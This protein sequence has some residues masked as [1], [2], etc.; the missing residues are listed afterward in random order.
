MLLSRQGERVKRC[1]SVS[2]E[3]SVLYCTDHF[4]SLK[5]ISPWAIWATSRQ[6]PSALLES[7]TLRGSYSDTPHDTPRRRQLW[8]LP[9]DSAHS[10][11]ALAPASPAPM[12]SPERCNSS[13]N[14]EG[15]YSK[16]LLWSPAGAAEAF[17]PSDCCSATKPQ[18]K[19]SP[20]R[21]S[22]ARILFT[23]PSQNEIDGFF[24]DARAALA[25]DRT[26]WSALMMKPSLLPGTFVDVC[27][28]QSRRSW[29]DCRRHS[30]SFP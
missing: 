12:F 2:L 13:G 28:R 18:I 4:T 26:P 27:R 24:R 9:M 22:A 5:N 11:G 29:G 23:Q 25:A 7:Q 10:A 16:E 15:F 20:G 6:T 19:P 21:P 14:G 30:R 3:E 1:E 17:F 8:T